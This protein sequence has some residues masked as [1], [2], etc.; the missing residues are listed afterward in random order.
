[1]MT[2]FDAAR[3]TG[4]FQGARTLREEADGEEKEKVGKE[5]SKEKW[6]IEEG[7]KFTLT[8]III[9]CPY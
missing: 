5:G 8:H 7:W 1:M 3:P 9:I 2:S 6:K 4:W